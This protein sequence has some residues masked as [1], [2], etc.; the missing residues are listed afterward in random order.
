MRELFKADIKDFRLIPCVRMT[1]FSKWSKRAQAYLKN[2]E[3][4]AWRFKTQVKGPY[5]L[6]DQPCILS[7]V[8]YLSHRRRVDLDNLLKSIQDALQKAGIVE[9]DY[10]IVGYDRVRLYRGEW[11]Q[12]I[13]NLYVAYKTF[14]LVR[15]M[16]DG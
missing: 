5:P 7:A 16:R 8:I 12:V 9:N 15:R 3:D 13:V 1:R 11:D 4:L 14:A 10:L 2:Q 6:I